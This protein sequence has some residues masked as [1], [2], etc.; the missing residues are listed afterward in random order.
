MSIYH[1]QES[2]GSWILCSTCYIS[3]QPF[4]L[5]FQLFYILWC[6]NDDGGLVQLPYRY[7]EQKPSQ[8]QWFHLE[9][10]YM[11]SSNSSNQIKVSFMDNSLKQTKFYTGHPWI[12]YSSS[13][14]PIH[15]C[16]YM[17]CFS[18]E[19]EIKHEWHGRNRER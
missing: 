1:R 17:D 10:L 12:F 8:L 16:I 15:I 11:Y 9:F 14:P 19:K 18:G 4:H 7:T 5:L 13:T 3:I 6:I 2:L